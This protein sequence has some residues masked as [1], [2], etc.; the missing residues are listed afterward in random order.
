MLAERRQAGP[1]EDTCV[2]T[3]ILQVE[4]RCSMARIATS[5]PEL[6]ACCPSREAFLA[7][8]KAEGLHTK[9]IFSANLVRPR[10]DRRAVRTLLTKPGNCSALSACLSLQFVLCAR[11]QYTW[12][13]I[14]LKQ[15]LQQ[16]SNCDTA[17]IIRRKQSNQQSMWCCDL[18][19]LTDP[20]LGPFHCTRST[21]KK[22]CQAVWQHIET[23]AGHLP[24]TYIFWSNRVTGLCM[25]A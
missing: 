8:A 14:R 12:T 10:H 1:A 17:R 25:P 9:E 24:P 18:P 2:T 11:C 21:R 3:D 16:A 15:E 23:S 22:H 7:M 13:A 20:V 5:E 4:K 19:R 6:H